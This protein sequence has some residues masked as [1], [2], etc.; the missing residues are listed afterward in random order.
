MKHWRI[1]LTG[2]VT[3]SSIILGYII[4]DY[5]Y[6]PSEKQAYQ[7]TCHH[8]DTLRIAYIG[9]SWAFGHNNHACIIPQ[10][11]NDSLHKPAIVESLGLS[12]LTSKEIYYELFENESLKHFMEKGHDY[13]FISAGIND[14]YKKMSILYYQKSMDCIIRFLLSNHIHPII[15]DIPDYNIERAFEKQKTSNKIIRHL[16]M[17]VND[18]PLDCK[19]EFRDALDKLILE[20]GYQDKVSIIRYQSWN[21]NFTKDL[22]NFYVGDQMHLNNRGYERL[23]SA[24][25]KTILSIYR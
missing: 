13:C 17:F 14:T 2:F 18:T 22:N 5:Y 15:Q 11:I 4:C 6:P 20:K 3:I 24:I 10:I 9:D 7:V 8:D 12:G 19:Q 23:D 16:S 1:I 21:S 25:A